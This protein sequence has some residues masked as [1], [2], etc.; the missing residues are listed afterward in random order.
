LIFQ[1][2]LRFPFHGLDGDISQPK[3]MPNAHFP[4]CY[5]RR[6]R[7]T[8]DL[9]EL[10]GLF[11]P[12]KIVH[13]NIERLIHY[14]IEVVDRPRVHDALRDFSENAITSQAFQ[15]RVGASL[16]ISQVGKMILLLRWH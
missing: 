8:L 3:P 16:T 14:I 5:Y 2:P 1:K 13:R 15:P 4:S 6:S 7:H 9:Y 12:F 10:Y 11:G